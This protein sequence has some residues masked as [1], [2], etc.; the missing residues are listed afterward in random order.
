MPAAKNLLLAVTGM[1]PQVVTET[2]YGLAKRQ[3]QGSGD[4]WPDELR[5]MTTSIGKAKMQHSLLEQGWLEKVCRE[6]ERSPIHFSADD[7]LV[8]PDAQGHTVDDAR[9]EA[10]HEALANFITTTVRDLTARCGA[11]GTPDYRLHASIAGG[12]KTMTFYLGYAM[13]LFGRHFDQMSHVLVSEG[14]EG[15]PEFYFPTRL[16]SAIKN[17][18]GETLCASQALVTLADIPFIR[19]RHQLP[20][21]VKQ[22]NGDINYRALIDLINLGDEPERIRLDVD[23][24]NLQLRVHKDVWGTD[25]V[26]TIPL[27][28]PVFLAFYIMLTEDSLRTAPEREII[29]RPGSRKKEADE[30]KILF[31]LLLYKLT[32]V[33]GHQSTLSDDDQLLKEMYDQYGDAFPMLERSMSPL[34]AHKAITRDQFSNLLHNIKRALELKLPKNMV[35]LLLPSPIFD[36]ETGALDSARVS[37]GGYGLRLNADH[38]NIL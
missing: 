35:D 2:L 5:I 33:L 26:M 27:N 16:P 19:M 25:P 11:D 14:Y 8:V 31:S 32:V 36:P 15:I 6:V 21:L 18:S 13:S 3:E 34:A 17:R 37:K 30:R 7:I 38:I 1:S 9:S 23:T 4:F 20:D 22:F 29:Q 12:R 10:D 28:N 24:Q